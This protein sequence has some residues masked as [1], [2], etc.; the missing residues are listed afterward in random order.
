MMAAAQAAAVGPHSQTSFV[1]MTNLVAVA[2]QS[3]LA[4]YAEPEASLLMGY[5]QSLAPPPPSE[6]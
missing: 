3:V 6:A 4:E 1:E 5:S 2:E